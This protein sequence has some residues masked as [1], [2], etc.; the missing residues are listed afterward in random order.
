LQ[1][2][3]QLLQQLGYVRVYVE[4]FLTTDSDPLLGLVPRLM[5]TA[6]ENDGLV[7]LPGKLPQ[8]Q[9]AAHPSF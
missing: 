4:L 5:F 3:D 9:I 6:L 8:A 2:R 1:P 7:Q